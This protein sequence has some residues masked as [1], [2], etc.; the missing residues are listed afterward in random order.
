MAA[1]GS[2]WRIAYILAVVGIR[3]V[4]YGALGVLAAISLGPAK[5][6]R[7]RIGQILLL[8][9]AIIT[10]GLVIRSLKVG[11]LPVAA[12]L[13]V[14][15][16]SCALGAWIGLAARYRWVKLTLTA[17]LALLGLTLWSLLG[18]VPSK[19]ASA[20]GEHLRHLIAEAPG[21]FGGDERFATL[22]KLAFA[23][24]RHESAGADPVLQNRAAILALGITLGHERIAGL[25]GM[26]V[27][28]DLIRQ[29]SAAGGKATLRGRGD[30]AKHYMASAALAV[31]ENPFFSDSAGLMKEV[32]DT[33]NNGSG[34]SFVDLAADK[35]GILFGE[36][37]TRDEASARLMQ[38]RLQNG[39]DVA[40][41]FPPVSDLP[42]GLTEEQFRNQF[43]GVGGSGYQ[44]MLQ[45]IDRRLSRC[46][47]LL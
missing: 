29:A 13:V 36:A 11:H 22:V 47:G 24:A 19:V 4:F 43:G 17:M 39:F 18:G 6:A 20:T 45:E 16:A 46:S 40:A 23:K 2:R 44:G 3:A 9:L 38:A 33:M 32:L 10:F 14:P 37:A 12:Q 25:A 31:L 41:F 30:L 42:E 15:A 21:Q 28:A 35:A 8:P 27:D 34:F 5:T 1:A 7:G 26:G